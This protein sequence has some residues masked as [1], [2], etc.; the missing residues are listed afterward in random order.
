MDKQSFRKV[1]KLDFLTNPES[2][3]TEEVQTGSFQRIADALEKIAESYPQLI[4]DRE[5]YRE[6]HRIS[7]NEISTF[8]RQVISLKGV[9]TKL[10]KKQR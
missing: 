7:Q 6:Q 2:T 9:I 4:K 5:F 3:N 1:S 8:R 10:K